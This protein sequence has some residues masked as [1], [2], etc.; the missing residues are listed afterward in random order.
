MTDKP[1][2]GVSSCLLGQ[3]VRYDGTDKQ[4]AFITEQL[5]PHVELLGF[6]PEMA[7]GLGAPRETL[8]LVGSL[9]QARAIGT[10]TQGHDVSEKLVG[11]AQSLKDIL[12]S[13]C[14]Y[15]VKTRSPSCGWQQVN[16]YAQLNQA[17]VGQGRGLYIAEIHR[18]H[19]TLPVIDEEQLQNTE[20]RHLFF[21]RVYAR[22]RWLSL[23]QHPLTL[24]GL[25]AF[26][27][28]YKYSIMARDPVAYQEL[29]RFVA[30]L[31]AQDLCASG[32]HY[33]ARLMK[34]LA[35]TPTRANHCNA[36]QHLMG[37]FKK[38]LSSQQKAAL[39]QTIENYRAHQVSLF[40]PIALLREHLLNCPNEYL[41]HQAYLFP[42]PDELRLDA[43]GCS[44]TE[45]YPLV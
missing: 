18:L 24:H 21:E 29:G 42:F 28:R 22:H 16:V 8:A 40:V 36:L 43:T 6:C 2:L 45:D 5:A 33:V 14:G 1:Q 9:D 10:Q 26:H 20:L 35:H 12:S 19:P 23:N 13:L 3:A 31:R 30:Q 41:S 38:H 27:S 15:I 37:Y 7:I 4:N 39:N 11:Y 32:P 17:P 44:D 34:I 25:T